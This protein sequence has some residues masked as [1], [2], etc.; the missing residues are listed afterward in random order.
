MPLMQQAQERNAP[1]A[2]AGAATPGAPETPGEEGGGEAFKRP[3]ISGFIPP[4]VADQVQRVTAAG[5]KL[6]YAPDMRQ[7]LMQEVNRQVPIPQKLAEATTGMMLT[8]DQ[9]SRGGIPAKAIFPAAMEL[10]GEAAEVLSASGQKVSQQDYNDAARLM[11]VLIA[12]KMGAKDEQI[13]G[14]AEKI[15]GGATTV[16]QPPPGGPAPGGPAPV[17]QEVPA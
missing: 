15:A 8:L 12:R 10:L 13:M 5:M 4:E 7:Q 9:K 11:F 6:M 3:D 2:G 16:E 14:A 1:P 17:G